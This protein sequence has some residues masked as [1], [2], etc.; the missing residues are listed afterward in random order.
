[1]VEHVEV[2]L[3]VQT[4]RRDGL[5]RPTNEFTEENPC[6]PVICTCKLEGKIWR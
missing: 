5:A 3:R 2:P 6:L 1:M 4:F